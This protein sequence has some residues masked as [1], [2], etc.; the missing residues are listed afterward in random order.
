MKQILIN[1]TKNALKFTLSGEIKIRASYDLQSE[2]LIV[3]V[4]DTGI[5]INKRE[6]DQLFSMFGKVKRSSGLNKE[7]I[8]IGLMICKRIIENSGGQI[9][10]HSDGENKGS[11][12]IFS[13]EMHLPNQ[14]T[15]MP[16]RVS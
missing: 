2:K 14:R 3:H 11:T 12:F 16:N 10:M 1:L 15:E 9:T 6:K 13:M 4:I 5:G 7:G 8:G